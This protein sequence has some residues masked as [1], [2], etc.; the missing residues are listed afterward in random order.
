MLYWP[1]LE[2]LSKIA[3]D[4]VAIDG[5]EAK[6]ALLT[7]ANETVVIARE[8][9]LASTSLMGSINSIWVAATDDALDIIEFLQGAIDVSILCIILKLWPEIK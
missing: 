8:L 2:A 7:Q 1:F 9:S 4:T 6:D 5:L 3:A